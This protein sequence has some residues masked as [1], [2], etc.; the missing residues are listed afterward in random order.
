M[1]AFRRF[2]RS[3]LLAVLLAPWVIAGIGAASNQLVLI[4]NHDKFPVMVNAYK[5]K[6]M[7]A[8]RETIFER[9]FGSH[10]ITAPQPAVEDPDGMIDEVH[11]VMTDKTHLNFLADIFDLHD[12]IYSI[13][14]FGLMLGDWLQ[15]FC[16]FV[17]AALIIRK[18]WEADAI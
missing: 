4:A 9:I 6:Q 11:C 18:C 3:T 2:L 15:T 5:L 16:P 14:D 10:P 1:N 12:A 17:W 7:Q 8:P 13:G